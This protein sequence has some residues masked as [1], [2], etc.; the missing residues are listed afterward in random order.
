MSTLAITLD[1]VKTSVTIEKY[2]GELF[3]DLPEVI[4]LR[5]NGQLRDINT[6]LVEGDLVETVAISTPDGLFILRHSSAH[7][8]AQAVQSLFPGTRLGIGPPIKD[9]FYYD[10]DSAKPFT[11][12]DLAAL[13]KEMSKIIKSNQRFRR[14]VVTDKEALAELSSE[15]FKCELISLK[16]EVSDESSVEV[17]GGELTIYDNLDRDGEIAWKDLCRGPHIPSTKSIPAV[18]LMR[19]SGAYWRG[20]EKNPML[21]RIYGTAWPSQSELDRYLHLLEEAEK[22]DHRRLG[23]ELD[24]FSFP[25]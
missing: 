23:S 12:D 9:G 14:R 15:P 16:S 3:R 19:S 11:P 17:G 22:R 1:G 2:T 20:S 5:I 7:V 13:E 6:P 25:E 10:F 8:L 21:Q 4:A 24:L 18:K